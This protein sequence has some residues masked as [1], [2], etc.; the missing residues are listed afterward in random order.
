MDKVIH[1][2]LAI[3]ELYIDSTLIL[4][5]GASINIDENFAYDSLYK[6]CFKSEN[7]KLHNYSQ[8]QLADIEKIFS[9]FNTGDFESVLQKLHQANIVNELFNIDHKMLDQKYKECRNLL[10]CAIQLIHKKYNEISHD[11]LNS[12]E[13]FISQFKAIYSLNYD[14]ILYWAMY[15]GNK[16]NSDSNRYK[17]GFMLESD[18]SELDKKFLHNGYYL[19]E[20]PHHPCDKATLIFYLHGNLTLATA[21]VNGISEEVKICSGDKDHLNL[22]IEKWESNNYIPLFVS[23]G[24]SKLKL[25]YIEESPYLSEVISRLK[26]TKGNLVIYGWSFNDQDAHIL[27]KIQEAKKYHGLQRI[28]VSVYL[29]DHKEPYLKYIQRVSDKLISV[30]FKPEEIDFFDAKSKGSWSN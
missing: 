21:A 6:Y 22:I 5:N 9:T 13:Q 24:L 15:I 11:E 27:D 26:S 25:N 14:L 19:L 12:I 30:G 8:E 16:K 28:A 29:K 2:W 4:G 7:S 1:E 10:I 17:D 20:Q 23:E 3:R 18:I